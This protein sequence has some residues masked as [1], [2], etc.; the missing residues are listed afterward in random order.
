MTGFGEGLFNPTDAVINWAR[1]NSLRIV[2]H[3]DLPNVRK[4]CPN[5]DVGAWL[6]G[7][8]EAL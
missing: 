5:F 3:R 7:G 1:K 4:S 6:A 8:M 2:G